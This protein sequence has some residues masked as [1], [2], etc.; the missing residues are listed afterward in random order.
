VQKRERS[1]SKPKCQRDVKRITSILPKLRAWHTKKVGERG[2]GRAGNR[3]ED[4]KESVL[5]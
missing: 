1:P 2:R 4:E 3:E 5:N